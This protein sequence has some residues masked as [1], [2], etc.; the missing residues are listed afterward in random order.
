M[1]EDDKKTEA[2]EA[3]Q[4]VNDTDEDEMAMELESAMMAQRSV[5]IRPPLDLTIDAAFVAQVPF[6]VC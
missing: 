6:V 5:D 1:A 3:A 2:T 4:A